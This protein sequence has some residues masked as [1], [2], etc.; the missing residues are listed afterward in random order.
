MGGLSYGDRN[1]WGWRSLV[2]VRLLLGGERECVAAAAAPPRELGL[3]WL[4]KRVLGL[5]KGGVVG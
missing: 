5:G 1:G 3:S 2:G 4:R